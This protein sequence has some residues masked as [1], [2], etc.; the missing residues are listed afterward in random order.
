MPKV[1]RCGNTMKGKR[2]IRSS[3]IQCLVILILLASL[4][5]NGSA[6][7]I[8]STHKNARIIGRNVVSSSSVAAF[9]HP[10]NSRLH[11]HHHHNA[12][13]PCRTTIQSSSASFRIQRLH[14]VRKDASS[15]SCLHVRPQDNLLSG[16]SEIGLGFTLGVLYSEFSIITTGCGPPDFSDSLER[17]CYQGMILLAS[18]A[19]FNRIV[20]SGKGLD[21]SCV[22]Y[23]GELEE[24]TLVQVRGAEYASAL[25]VVGAFVALGFQYG[26]G[27]DMDGLSGIDIDLCR[28]LRDLWWKNRHIYLPLW[29]HRA[30]V[31]DCSCNSR[32]ASLDLAIFTFRYPLKYM[33]TEA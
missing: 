10:N 27:A 14:P 8:L 4:V 18:L 31:S 20:T 7:S 9:H 13:L 23:F 15:S 11:H 5:V 3:P 26:R 32:E 12:R 30:I 28:A 33:A 24:G 6:S 29:K 17:L 19:L 25:A 16:I 2:S 1:T 21:A 22:D